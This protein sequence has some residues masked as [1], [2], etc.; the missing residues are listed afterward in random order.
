MM[1]IIQPTNITNFTVMACPEKKLFFK[2]SVCSTSVPV[3]KFIV[4]TNGTITAL[5]ND[6]E[7]IT[8]I[9]VVWPITN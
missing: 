7:N 9:D 6:S 5:N 8:C 4:N 3:M 2:L 1:K